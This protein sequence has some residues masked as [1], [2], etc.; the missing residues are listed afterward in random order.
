MEFHYIFS[1]NTILHH[2]CLSGNLSLV[3]FLLSLNKFDIN[4]V[5]ILKSIFFNYVSKRLSY[6]ISNYFWYK[7]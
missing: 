7:W 3:K 5:N 1:N 4:A 2:A 6:N